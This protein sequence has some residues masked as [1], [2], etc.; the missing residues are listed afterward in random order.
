MKIR[1]FAVAA[2]LMI[3]GIAIGTSAIA[4]TKQVV[5]PNKTFTL[6]DKKG[7]QLMSLKPNQSIPSTLQCV[8]VPCPANF[9]ERVVCWKCDSDGKGSSPTK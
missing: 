1:S 6:F 3:A 9:D 7:K 5:P 8:Q 2:S 4:A